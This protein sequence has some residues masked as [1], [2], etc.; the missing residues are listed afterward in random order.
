MFK[1]LFAE[2]D[3]ISFSDFVRYA[4]YGPNGYYKKN[5]TIGPEGDFYTSP[6]VS[7]LFGKTIGY[8]F[9]KIILE[10]F[11]KDKISIVE[12]GSNNGEL[13][14]NVLDFFVGY[15]LDI[16]ERLE[17]FVVEANL[18]AKN[19]IINN[20]A[21]Y[22][23]QITIIPSISKIKSRTKESIIL[24]NE[25]FDALPFDRCV[26]RNNKFFQTNIFTDKKNIFER[27]DKA[28]K[29]LIK[30]M[31]RFNLKIKENF[32][33]EIPS[34]EYEQIFKDL[35]EKFDKMFFLISDYGDK[36]DYFNLSSDP[37]G[38]ARCFYNHQV[39]RNFY[40]NIFNQDIT[41]DVNFSLLTKIAFNY[42]FNEVDFVSQNRFLLDNNI[43]DIY[44]N[45]DS[46]EKIELTQQLKKLVLP[47]FLGEKF[48][49]L[50]LRN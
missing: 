27:Q 17:V 28:D 50:S 26:S 21:S 29:N 14:K 32:F 20:L 31:K 7:K 34:F 25:L 2:K 44:E 37:F 13:I 6:S 4:L 12:I 24:C 9:S 48:K 10:K 8:F 49:F 43:L 22:K 36:S 42:G 40:K 47:N 3:V 41:H 16:H 46:L 1:T 33:F 38:T 5:F 23:D 18:S 30:F 35:S 15:H 11:P 45:F 19:K 39:S